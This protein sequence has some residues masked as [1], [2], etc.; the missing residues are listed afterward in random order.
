MT[1]LGEALLDASEAAGRYNRSWSTPV[2]LIAR[3]Q[4][5][6]AASVPPASAQ[7]FQIPNL[8]HY[9]IATLSLLASALGASV[10]R[11]QEAYTAAQC[12][13]CA[14][15]NAPTPPVRIFG[16]VYYVGTRGLSA[17]LLTSTSGHILLDAGLPES[18][19][20]ILANIRAAGFRVEDIKLIV[21]SHAHY[22][23][24]GGL[25]AVQRASGA[26]VAT[27]AASADVIRRGNSG[28]RDP[29][30]G[31]L[32]PYPAVRE[33]R[34]FAD[35]DTLRV[36]PNAITA[37]LTPGHTPGGTSWTW[38]SCDGGGCLDFVYADSQTPVSAD[39]FLF[40]RNTTY[41]T[42]L[43]DFAKSYAV[44][45]SLTC[46]MLLTPHPGASQLWERLESA[47]GTASGLRDREG[48]R[49]YAATARQNLARRI[50]SEAAAK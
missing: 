27:S 11:G 12:P 30:Y 9:R 48:C 4:A 29:Q 21:N 49:R 45:E 25:A 6:F 23:H 38:R 41:P 47:K 3:D 16:S 43:D 50:A 18:A 42:V 10:A 2:A 33:L 34:E 8:M 26:I 32:L 17:I 22:D 36:G 5:P 7:R 28:P 13:P 14:E 40:S 19:P 31:I 20:L 15:W 44:L 46:D 1:S 39:G 35:G 37:H 24:A